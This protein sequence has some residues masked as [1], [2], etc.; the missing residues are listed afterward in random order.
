MV[1]SYWDS[2]V[3]QKWVQLWSLALR[4]ARQTVTVFIGGSLLVWVIW[5]MFWGRDKAW[6][7]IVQILIP[8]GAG[9]IIAL[10]VIGVAKFGEAREAVRREINEERRVQSIQDSETLQIRVWL[11][12]RLANDASW[13][14]QAYLFGSVTHSTY[15]TSDVDIV[16]LFNKMSDIEYIKKNEILRS[17]IESFTKTFNR[18]VHLQRF[19]ARE[20]NNFEE[21]LAKQSEPV[22]LL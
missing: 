2:R 14:A 12:G 17:V 18:P 5:W 8:A 9:G 4:N 13:I 16:I 1:L 11:S 20:R 19:L 6:E 3:L 15:Q 22:K 10:A 7:Q 21:F